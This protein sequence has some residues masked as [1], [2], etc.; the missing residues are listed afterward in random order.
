ML[1]DYID[2]FI[3]IKEKNL[4]RQ[5]FIQ[6]IYVLNKNQVGSEKSVANKNRGFEYFDIFSKCIAIPVCLLIS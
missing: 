1:K 6:K 4:L 3:Q 5:K 2:C